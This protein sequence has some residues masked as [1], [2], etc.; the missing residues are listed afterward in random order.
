[1]TRRCVFVQLPLVTKTHLEPEEARYYQVFWQVMERIFQRPFPQGAVYTIPELPLWVTYLANG[2]IDAGWEP[3]FVDLA[4]HTGPRS[5]I[6]VVALCADIA[7]SRPDCVAFSPFT[8]NYP[9]VVDLL[10]Q[11]RSTIGERIPFLV[12]GAHATALPHECVKDGFDVAILGKG[13]ETL[14]R[15]LAAYPDWNE[16][17]LRSIPGIVYVDSTGTPIENASPNSRYAYLHRVPHISILPPDYPLHFARVYCSL[18]C[19]YGCSFCADTNWIRMRPHFKTVEQVVTEI[20]Q[21]RERFGINLFFMGDEVFTLREPFVRAICEALKGEHISWFCQTRANLVKPSILRL[22]RES[23][24]RLIQ[25]GAESADEAILEGLQ[26]KVTLEMVTQACADAKDAGL[27]VLTYWMVGGPME[28]RG[29]ALKT[30]DAISML[31]EKG[32]TDLADYYI[33]TPYPGT[34]LY[35]DPEKYNV[36]ISAGDFA[37]WREDQPS[38]MKTQFLDQA[39][40]FD[41]WKLGID[42]ISSLMAHSVE[43]KCRPLAVGCE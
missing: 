34:D 8:N 27:H 7:A 39:E 3:C 28:S 24:C 22:M 12:G 5:R 16:K 41:L 4:R 18:G 36:T 43:I 20:R 31:F 26:K 19:P 25:I 14:F 2:V 17:S 42:R 29:T 38:V 13:E 21:I 1:M 37:A 32:L 6:D 10:A 23:G 15:L 35:R 40:I 33:C 30:L 9:L 11:L